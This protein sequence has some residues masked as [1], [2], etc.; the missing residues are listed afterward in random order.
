MTNEYLERLEREVGYE[1]DFAFD[2]TLQFRRYELE[3]TVRE[4]RSDFVKRYAWAIPNEEALATIARY[5]PIVEIGAGTG[6]WAALLRS[7]GVEV[8]AYDRAPYN[9][10]WA[11]NRW[12]GVLPCRSARKIARKWGKRG[13][14]LFLCWPP[15][16]GRLSSDALEAYTG[17]YLIYVGEGDGGC[18]GDERFHELLDQHWTL[19][20]SVEIP[21]WWS[22]HDRLFVYTRTEER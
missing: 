12:T 10:R 22:I 11:K 5:A 7:R 20:E 14:T 8:R 19:I 2:C 3:P 15:Y 21:Q 16:Q 18:T 6:Y 1:T 9:N 17:Q 13:H 4:L